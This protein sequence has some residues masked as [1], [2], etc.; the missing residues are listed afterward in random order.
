MHKI[1]NCETGLI[2]G[3]DTASFLLFSFDRSIFENFSCLQMSCVTQEIRR[4]WPMFEGRC[5][6]WRI[7]LHTRKRDETGRYRGDLFGYAAE[8]FSCAIMMWMGYNFPTLVE[9]FFRPFVCPLKQQHINEYFWL[10]SCFASFAPRWHFDACLFCEKSHEKLMK[11]TATWRSTKHVS[12]TIAWPASDH[13]S[14]QEKSL[15]RNNE[16]I[17]QFTVRTVAQIYYKRKRAKSVMFFYKYSE[18]MQT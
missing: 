9:V 18:W 6:K 16:F 5:E 1:R 14:R 10:I 4:L 15:N 17:Y 13:F 2:A 3:S 11:S 8:C 7:N 12:T